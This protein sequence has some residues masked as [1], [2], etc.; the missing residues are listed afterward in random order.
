MGAR[1]PHTTPN[2]KARNLAENR[3]P[4]REG[5]TFPCATPKKTGEDRHNPRTG[6]PPGTPLEDGRRTN[7]TRSPDEFDPAPTR[8]RRVTAP[9]SIGP[10]RPHNRPT[11]HRTASQMQRT[12]TVLEAL[13][14]HI[15]AEIGPVPRRDRS[16][17]APRSVRFRVEIGPVCPVG[18]RR[19]SEDRFSVEGGR[20]RALSGPQR[21]SKGRYRDSGAHPPGRTPWG[22]TFLRGVAPQA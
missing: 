19:P 16:S 4:P 3:T 10:R 20:S 18:G 5:P 21:A 13:T 11:T 22:R 1:Q 2:G 14:R 17:S 9:H 15:R 7:P 8:R 12:S 6:R